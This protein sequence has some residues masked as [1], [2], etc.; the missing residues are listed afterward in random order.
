M[1]QRGQDGA[2]LFLIFGCTMQLFRRLGGTEEGEKPIILFPPLLPPEFVYR[3]ADP[4][5]IKPSRRI[6][7][8]RIA[9]VHELPEHVA[10]I[11]SALP[12]C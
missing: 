1:F 10:A 7:V 12:G 5:P 3:S 8:L 6:R 2:D 9:T 4:G 11:S